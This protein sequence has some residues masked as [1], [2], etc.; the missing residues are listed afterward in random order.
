MFTLVLVENSHHDSEDDHDDDPDVGNDSEGA[1]QGVQGRVVVV[2]G[3]P[4]NRQG[5]DL[6]HGQLEVPRHEVDCLKG[7]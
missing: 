7:R 4:S 6:E 3:R 5:K 1:G 2:F